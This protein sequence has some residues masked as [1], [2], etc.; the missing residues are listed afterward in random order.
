VGTAARRGSALGLKAVQARH[1]LRRSPW[2]VSALGLGLFAAGVLVLFATP[3][4]A[5]SAF[6]L[7]VG[8]A[9][10]LVGVLGGRVQLEGFEFLGAKLHVS[11]VV[12]RRLELAEAPGQAGDPNG[13]SLRRQA[14]VLQKLVGFY[15]LYEHI[16]R[17]E[18]PGPER[19]QKLDQL[20]KSMRAVGREA[21][22]DPAEVIGWFHEGTDALRVIALNLMLVN[23]EYR[24]FLAVIEAIDEPHSHF[25]QYY[26]L[27][28]AGAML[29]DLEPLQRRLLAEAIERA[30]RKRRLRRD[31]P[32]TV[33]SQGVLE[34]LADAE[35]R[36]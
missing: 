15:G 4:Q 1:R 35:G 3:H 12:K 27:K 24:D 34:D 5:R 9:L 29:P 6:L 19:T 36:A 32:L 22:F 28:L 26:A 14:V 23:E 18:P 7:A 2:L 10:L 16:R 21:E 31:R 20:A 30:R 25:E 8:V 17:V 33:L 11:E 13:T